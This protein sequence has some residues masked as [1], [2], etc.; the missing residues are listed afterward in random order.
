MNLCIR[1]SKAGTGKTTK[2]LDEV[3][4]AQRAGKEVVW[5]DLNASFCPDYAKSRGVDK[6]G[7]FAN[8][9]IDA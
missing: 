1:K 6:F 9:K 2:A 3:A 4:A 5:I 7:V 8:S